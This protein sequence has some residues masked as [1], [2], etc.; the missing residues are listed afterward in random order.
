MNRTFAVNSSDH[1]VSTVPLLDLVFMCALATGRDKT[2]TNCHLESS[3]RCLSRAR[4]LTAK[5][6]ASRGGKYPADKMQESPSGGAICRL[7]SV[8]LVDRIDVL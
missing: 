4:S 7:E 2:R 5:R 1:F 6:L 3:L 8:R